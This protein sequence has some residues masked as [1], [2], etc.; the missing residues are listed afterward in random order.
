MQRM[1]TGL[2]F[3]LMG[4]FFTIAVIQYVKIFD[5]A[6][7]LKIQ[8]L[9]DAKE[10]SD[11]VCAKATDSNVE[12]SRDVYGNPP[13]TPYGDTGAAFGCDDGIVLIKGLGESMGESE[14]NKLN[15]AYG[16]CIPN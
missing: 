14:C 13:L 6:N 16:R 9:A 11:T 8:I 5:T 2:C 4:F 10:Y 1:I 15:P 3:L 7:D 12:T